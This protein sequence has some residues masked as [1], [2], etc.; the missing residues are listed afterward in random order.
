VRIVVEDDGRGIGVQAMQDKAREMGVSATGD[1]LQDLNLV[2]ERGMTTQ[3]ASDVLSG[4]GVG[5][6]AVR[7]QLT[8]LGGTAQIV[9]VPGQG[10]TFTFTLPR[11][12]SP[13]DAP[14]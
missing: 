5:L 13:A 8:R 12:S 3:K 7:E 2:F 1:A 14:E 10:T 4:R 9:S 11:P 6:F